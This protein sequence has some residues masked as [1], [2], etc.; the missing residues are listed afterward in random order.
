MK[1]LLFSL[2]AMVLFTDLSFAQTSNENWVRMMEEYKSSVENV[3]SKECPKDMDL[4]KFKISLINGSVSLSE[5]SKN[6]ILQFSEPI[7]KYGLEFA[8]KN[9][10]EST[11]ESTL[12]FYSSFSPD[13]KVENGNII[14]AKVGDPGLTMAD[15]VNC[16]VAALGADALYS[17]AV[18]G[19]TSWSMA[20]LTTTFTGVAKRFLG[21]I[22]VGIAVISFGLCLH[23]AYIN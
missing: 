2:M 7:K 8:T 6:A 11:D 16:A 18:S 22:G 23:Q 19:A 17:L 20:A 9:K 14:L 5:N 15:Y 1:N 10:L 4:N 21:P 13:I 3:L 12:I